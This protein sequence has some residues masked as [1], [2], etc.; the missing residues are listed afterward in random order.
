MRKFFAFSLVSLMVFSACSGKVQPVYE[1]HQLNEPQKIFNSSTKVL[2]QDYVSSVISFANNFY[3]VIN[4]GENKVFSPLSI[5]T[6]FSMLYEGAKQSSKEEL[7]TLLGYDEYINHQEAI[8]NMLLNNAIKTTKPE[9]VLDIAQSFWV[10]EMFNNELNQDFVNI[11]TEYYFAEAFQGILQ[12]DKMHEALAQYINDKTNNFFDLTGEDFKDFGGILWLLNTLY[13]KAVWADQ[14]P[15]RSNFESSFTNLD[16]S[17]NNVTF[18]TNII[19]GNYYAGQDYLISSYALEGGLKFN[20]L[21]PNSDSDYQAVL[22]D[23][24]NVYNLLDFPKNSFSK[25]NAY[26]TYKI[27]KFKMTSNYDLKEQFADLG[28]SKIFDPDESDLSD[29]FTSAELKKL[30]VEKA[31]HQAGIDVN[32]E[33]IEAAAYTIIQITPTSVP[34]PENLLDFVV[35]RPFAYTVSDNN[36]LPLFMGLVTNLG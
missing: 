18:M 25:T 34:Q 29:I 33:G 22:A 7:A 6:C 21:L 4:D 1:M 17:E 30:Y 15:A 26:I 9:V 35:D 28:V 31:I 23:V 2:N 36:G 27:P 24:D 20:I 16:K 14:F 8:K 19:D 5:A 32:N 12:S 10:D 11:L 3:Q 13:L